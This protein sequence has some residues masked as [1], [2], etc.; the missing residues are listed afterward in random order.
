MQ[1]GD[2]VQHEYRRH[3]PLHLVCFQLLLVRRVVTLIDC[4]A[5]SRILHVWCLVLIRHCP[6]QLLHN[7][8]EVEVA[9]AHQFTR[10]VCWNSCTWANTKE[11][12]N[13][14]CPISLQTSAL[15]LVEFS[16]RSRGPSF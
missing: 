5:L 12:Q 15:E 9:Q 1:S 13:R 2:T 16:R 7:S 3:Y 6:P 4:L 8:L 14:T 10:G 11:L